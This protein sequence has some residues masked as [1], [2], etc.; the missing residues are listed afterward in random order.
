M[1]LFDLHLIHGEKIDVHGG[2]YRLVFSKQPKTKS[3]KLQELEENERLNAITTSSVNDAIKLY[4]NEMAKT[5]L[6]LQSLTSRGRQV[7][8]FGASGRGNMILGE[9]KIGIETVKYVIDE[10]PERIGRIMAQ[11]GIPIRSLSSINEMPDTEILILAW[12]YKFQILKKWPFRKN[13]FIVPL[14]EFELIERNQ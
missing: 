13:R 11:S 2:S 6:Y 3:L 9:L 4:K 8:A 10:S 7:V 5:K 1:K 12:N 14:P